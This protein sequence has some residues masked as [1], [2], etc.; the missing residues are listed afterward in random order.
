MNN[1]TK[2]VTGGDKNLKY[3]DWRKVVDKV[4]QARDESKRTQEMCKS[5]FPKNKKLLAGGFT[6][7]ELKMHNANLLEYCEIKF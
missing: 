7:F 4:I 2:A 6:G 3:D 1:N 5:L